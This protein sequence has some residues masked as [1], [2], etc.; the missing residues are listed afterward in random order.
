MWPRNVPP[1]SYRS[2]S[3]LLSSDLSFSRYEMA[4]SPIGFDVYG[5]IDRRNFQRDREE[6]L[7][8]T[9]ITLK[10]NGY[11]KNTLWKPKEIRTPQNGSAEMITR[12]M[13]YENLI[14]K[15]PVGKDQNNRQQLQNQNGY[16]NVIQRGL[17]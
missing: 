16:Q 1:P 7:R 5:K 14:N 10:L 9:T 15:G 2:P 11:T 3:R 8:S 12:W 6:E 13:Y 17:S 4:K